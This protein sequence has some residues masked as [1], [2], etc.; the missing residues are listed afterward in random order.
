MMLMLGI[1]QTWSL[2]TKTGS[3][4]SFKG[5]TSQNSDEN[6]RKRKRRNVREMSPETYE[7]VLDYGPSVANFRPVQRLRVE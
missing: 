5:K 6:Q 4:R 3:R 7:S 1:F 2:A